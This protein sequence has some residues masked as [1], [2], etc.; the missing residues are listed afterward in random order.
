MKPKVMVAFDAL[1]LRKRSIIEMINSKMFF[2]LSTPDA[3][4]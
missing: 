3:V 2:S 1:L 4:L